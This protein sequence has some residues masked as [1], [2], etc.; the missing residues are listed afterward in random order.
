MRRAVALAVVAGLSG[1]GAGLAQ[2][3]GAGTG[4]AEEGFVACPAQ[5]D[6]EQF[7]AADGELRPEGCRT[8]SIVRVEGADGR[9]IC[10]LDFGEPGDGVLAELREAAVPTTWWAE[11][12]AVAA[13][14]R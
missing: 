2:E 11:C 3:P 5:D 4:T 10:A 1:A 12:D 13:Q 14:L 9:Q 7:L 8:V 6:I